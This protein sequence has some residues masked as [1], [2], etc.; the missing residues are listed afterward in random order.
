MTSAICTEFA[1]S[2]L[3]A[4]AEYDLAQIESMFDEVGGDAPLAAQFP[5]PQGFQY[6]KAVDADSLVSHLI[7]MK[8]GTIAFDF[9]M[10]F[11]GD[12]FRPMMIRTIFRGSVESH[13]VCLEGVVPT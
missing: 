12:D 9:E 10:P 13:T 11:E 7:E 1:V 3:G 4:L 6:H 5:E 2:L 8:D